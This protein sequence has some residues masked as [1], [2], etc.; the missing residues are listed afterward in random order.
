[1]LPILDQGLQ[2]QGVT[3]YR[4][5]SAE[6]TEKDWPREALE[7]DREYW[8]NGELLKE[9]NSEVRRKT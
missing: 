4:E 2:R 7:L 8:D 3:G 9:V 1:M 5:S 6:L